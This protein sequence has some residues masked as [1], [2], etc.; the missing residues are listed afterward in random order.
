[1]LCWS[2]AICFSA[3]ASSEND[4]GSMNS[5]RFVLA[6][7]GA[8]ARLSVLLRELAT[9]DCLCCP[10]TGGGCRARVQIEALKLTWISLSECAAAAIDFYGSIH[11]H[12][13]RI[14]DDDWRAPLT[15]LSSN[16]TVGHAQLIGDKDRGG[17][18]QLGVAARRRAGPDL[19]PD[20]SEVPEVNRV[21]LDV[22]SKPPA[23]IEWE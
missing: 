23:T 9:V 13:N 5:P 8:A 11:Y 12:Q 2:W 1:M 17:L 21:V 4:Q 14:K 20:H 18:Q 3:A 16:P 15:V 6:G 7:D 22:T 10:A 19:H